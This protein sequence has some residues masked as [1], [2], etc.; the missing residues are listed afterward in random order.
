MWNGEATPSFPTTRSVRQRDPISP[1]LFVLCLERLDHCIDKAVG[2]GAWKPIQILRG[3]PK[4]S[5]LLFADDILLFAEASIGQLRMVKNCLDK[6]C[7]ASEQRVS[8]A[9]SKI[10]VSSNVRGDLERQLSDVSGIP[11]TRDL[12]NYSGNAYFS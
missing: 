11:S 9:K 3:G 7:S 2:S 4:I 10:F 5:H 6:F 1:Y 12:G 8:V